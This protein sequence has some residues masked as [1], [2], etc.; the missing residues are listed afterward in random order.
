MYLFGNKFLS[1]KKS[2]TLEREQRLKFFRYKFLS[3][4]ERNWFA[5]PSF[6]PH[7]DIAH[8]SF[9]NQNHQLGNITTTTNVV[10]SLIHFCSKNN[11]SIVCD[12]A[13]TARGGRFALLFAR[14]AGIKGGRSSPFLSKTLSSSQT[15][16]GVS[17]KRVEGSVAG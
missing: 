11:R 6:A 12:S 2:V 5:N 13:L 8:L 10:F 14:M 15:W 17:S 3:I 1:M 7:S 9:V 4:A 16:Y